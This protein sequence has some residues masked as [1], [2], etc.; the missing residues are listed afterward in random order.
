MIRRVMR[1]HRGRVWSGGLVQ[2]THEG[3]NVLNNFVLH[4][5]RLGIFQRDQVV[6]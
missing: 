1:G 2:F 3:V 5:N 4:L 6:T